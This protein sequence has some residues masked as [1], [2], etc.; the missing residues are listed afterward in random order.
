MSGVRRPTLLNSCHWAATASEAKFRIE[1][2]EQVRRA[3][4]VIAL[5]DGAVELIERIA[6]L[7]SWSGAHFLVYEHE[8]SSLLAEEAGLTVEAVLAGNGSPD[9]VL[10][11]VSGQEARLNAE[12]DGA[13]VVLMVA[14]ADAGADGAAMIGAAC[15]RGGVMTAGLIVTDRASSSSSVDHTVSMLRPYAMVLLISQDA[16][17]LPELLVAL[18]A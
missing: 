15:A 12:L 5:D 9:A 6:G 18:R 7:D 4:R 14:T 13:D 1:G 11:T 8:T 10:K 16:D 3:T 17:D 2:R